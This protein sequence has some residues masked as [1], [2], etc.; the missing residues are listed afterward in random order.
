MTTGRVYT[1]V[2]SGVASPAAAFDFLEINAAAEK[3]IRLLRMRI[4][5][6]S[7]PTTEE[8]QLAVTIQRAHSTSGSGGSAPTPRPLK[9]ASAAAGFTAETMNT[10]QA[11]GGS[12]LV[13]FEDAMNIRAGY[14]MAFAPEEAPES[15]NGTR[16][17]V[18]CSAPADAV[19]F[20][21]TF[22]IEE[23]G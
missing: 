19:T 8:E 6:T 5:Q 21:A 4:A 10:T 2:I 13:L 11:T 16:F 17:V 23:L 14:D 22:W 9:L 3:P 7:E 20:R 15:V 12:P 18:Q 1:V